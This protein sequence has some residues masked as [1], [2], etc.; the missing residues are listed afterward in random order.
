MFPS[1]NILSMNNFLILDIFGSQPKGS[2]YASMIFF[3][4]DGD[5]KVTENSSW[6]YGAKTLIEESGNSLIIIQPESKI[7]PHHIKAFESMSEAWYCTDIETL[8]IENGEIFRSK[9]TSDDYEKLTKINRKNTQA[10]PEHCLAYY[11]YD[12][13]NM[14]ELNNLWRR[15]SPG[16]N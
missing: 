2:T 4:A 12:S 13:S 8:K 1:M 15:V 9:G 5:I 7:V 10:F 14:E 11:S 16:R 6:G 3:E